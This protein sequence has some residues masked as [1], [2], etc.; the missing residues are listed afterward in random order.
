MTK[1]PF[2]IIIVLRRAINFL[3]THLHKL[4]V[5]TLILNRIYIYTHTH[6]H[7]RT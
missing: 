5:L 1:D 6:T 2:G 7:T 4:V 3:V